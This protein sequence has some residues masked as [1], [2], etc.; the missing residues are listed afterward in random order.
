MGALAAGVRGLVFLPL[1][2]SYKGTR[3][4]TRLLGSL[5]FIQSALIYTTVGFQTSIIH[6]SFKGPQCAHLVSPRCHP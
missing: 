5:K 6:G 4:R 3:E 2:A 1:N